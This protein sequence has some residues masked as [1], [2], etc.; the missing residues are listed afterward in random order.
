MRKEFDLERAATLR[1]AGLSFVELA[2]I[3]GVTP[4]TVHCRLEDSYREKRQQRTNELRRARNG[5]VE[6]R[7]I[8]VRHHAGKRDTQI[9]RDWHRQL[10]SM[11][12]DTRNLTAR[13]CG[14]PL[15]ERSALYQKMKGPAP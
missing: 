15:F 11:P 13:V 8:S 5:T 3:F 6:R 14:D 2:A 7:E 9:E 1:A 4:D 12:A 10:A